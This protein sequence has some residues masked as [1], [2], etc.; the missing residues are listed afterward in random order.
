MKVKDFIKKLKRFDQD[1]NVCI[2]V[3]VMS[4]S[5]GVAQV[6]PSEEMVHAT[7]TGACISAYLPDDMYVC[8]RKGKK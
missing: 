3:R 4:Q 5:Y 2:D 1:A 7:Y 6:E 8:R